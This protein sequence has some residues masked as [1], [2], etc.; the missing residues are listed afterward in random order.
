MV[1]VNNNFY[2]NIGLWNNGNY[3]GSNAQNAYG[4][5]NL[6]ETWGNTFINSD[7]NTPFNYPTD[8]FHLKINSIGKNAGTDGTDIGIYGGLYPWK[9]GSIPSNPH[10]SL[11]KVDTKTN[12][13]GILNATFQVTPQNN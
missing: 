13:N 7:S 8:N 5:N 1:G 9:D 12:A 10:I 2:N 4:I 11:L 3:T 6:T